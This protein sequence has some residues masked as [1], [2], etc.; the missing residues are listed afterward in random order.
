MRLGAWFAS[1]DEAGDELVRALAGMS[2]ERPVVLALPRGGVPVGLKVAKALHAPLDLLMVRK[3]GVPWQ[4]ELAAAA[5]VDGEKHELVLNEETMSMARLSLADLEPSIKQE[6]AEIERRRSIYLA[7]RPAVSVRDRSV[8]IVDDGIAT[9]TTVRVAIRALRKRAPKEL[10]IAVPVAPP[11]TI[12]VL[13][14]EVDRVVCVSEP[15]P[16]YA[17]GSFYGDFHAMDDAEVT[18][19]LAEAPRDV[20]PAEAS[21]GTAGPEGAPPGTAGP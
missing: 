13:R 5:I 19:L 12:A 11:D 3:I 20:Q 1:R 6:L 18:R 7:G 2:F 4:P 16:F 15:E 8:I 17:I 10:V 9:G 14:K 21:V